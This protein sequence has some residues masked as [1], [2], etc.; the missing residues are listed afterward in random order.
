MPAPLIKGVIKVIAWGVG[1]LTAPAAVPVA[2]G[3]GGTVI[4]GAGTAGVTAGGVAVTGL[5]AWMTA[6]LLSSLT[7]NS[8]EIDMSSPLGA[9][10]SDIA[11]QLENGMIT[12]EEANALMREAISASQTGHMTLNAMDV[13]IGT[14]EEKMAALARLMDATHGIAL[15]SSMAGTLAW[16][17]EA[18][19]ARDREV[20][21]AM[22]GSNNFR[23]KHITIVGAFDRNN[24]RNFTVGVKKK[25]DPKCAEDIAAAQL[26]SSGVARENIIFTAAIRPRY[27]AEGKNPVIPVCI[28]CQISYEPSNFLPK[29]PYVRRNTRTGEVGRFSSMPESSHMIGV[30]WSPSR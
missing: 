11:M 14:I 23:D 10:A 28:R 6:D 2:V 1:K 25:G 26:M 21:I 17:Q 24:P 5:A 7:T 18:T 3:G 16:G 15:A 29:V 12:V 27:I 19:Q 4:A 30:I 22:S 13:D 20:A 8:G 9:I